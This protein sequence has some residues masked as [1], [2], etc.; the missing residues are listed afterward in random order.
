MRI[1]Q[2]AAFVLAFNANAIAAPP[3]ISTATEPSASCLAFDGPLVTLSGTTF[4]RIYFGPPGYG[5]NPE[6]DIR[7]RA[8][9]LLLDAPLCVEENSASQAPFEGN[10][11]VIQLAAIHI[12]PE[13]VAK[14]QGR[15]VTVRGTL[16][17]ALTGHHRTAVLVDVH[18]ISVP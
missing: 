3:T 12:S 18:S 16:F 9:L 15:R 1:I 2:S 5:L 8:T 17:H 7:E 13:S 10:V 4:S 6:Q 11:I 14:A